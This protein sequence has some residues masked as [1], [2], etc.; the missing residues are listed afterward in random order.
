[1][2]LLISILSLVGA[3]LWSA[4]PVNAQVNVIQE[5]NH[6]S[7]DGL[8]I[9]SAFTRSAAANVKRDLNLM[10]LFPAMFTLSRFT[11]RVVQAVGRELL[12]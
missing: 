4:V 7:R 1:M 2:K 10:V 3:G 12:S 9:D 5:H 6:L 11:S 8:Y